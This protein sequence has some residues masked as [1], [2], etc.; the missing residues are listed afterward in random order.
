LEKGYPL[1]LNKLEY[2]SPE[3]DLFQVSLKLAK[4]F[5]RGRF[6]NDPTHF[7]IFVIISSLKGTWPFI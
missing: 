4:W 3:D 2:P 7:Y 5:W 1:G 6:L